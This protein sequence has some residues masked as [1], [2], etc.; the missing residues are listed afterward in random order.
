MGGVPHYLKE[1]RAEKSAVQ[2]ID[3]ICFSSDGL[4]KHEFSRLYPS[5]FDQSE[6]HIAVIRALATGKQ[7]LTRAQIITS[8]KL[9]DN[10][11]TSRV[12][13][14]L[15][16]SGFVTAYFPFGKVKKDTLY[17]LTD[18]YSLFYIQFIEPH[19]NE[20]GETWRQLSQSPQYK[21]WSGYAFESLCM[22]HLA[23][24]KS[25]MSIGGIYTIASTFYK[26]GTVDDPGA[27]IDL[28]LDRADQ[29]INL[30]EIKFKTDT[31]SL[32]KEMADNM[33]QKIRVFRNTT[34]TNKQIFMVLISAFGLKHNQYSLGLVQQ[35][36]TLDDLFL[37]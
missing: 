6:R 1:I 28:L 11:N 26:K 34:K 29:T 14:E 23:A 20:D 32:N 18:E 10:G 2:N 21:T 3:D 33:E 30:F 22:K 16:E 27:Q 37:Q 17:R 15:I 12:I 35:V 36:L 4:L 31:I 7:G 8:S 24:L 13:E 9:A 25:A 5:L 19:K